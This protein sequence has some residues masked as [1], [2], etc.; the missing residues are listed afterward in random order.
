MQIHL[1][2][3]FLFLT[4]IEAQQNSCL[5]SCC[6]GQSCNLALLPTVYVQYCTLEICIARC[7]AT[8]SQC[9]ENHPYGQISVQCGLNITA[10]QYNCKCDCCNTGSNLCLPSY[11]GNTLTYSCQPGACS[12]A[13]SNQFPY[14]CVSNQNGQ[15]QGTCLGSLTT[16]SVTT[17]VAPWLGNV[18]SC[19][20]CQTGSYCSPTYVGA[21]SAYQCSSTDCTQACRNSYPSSCPSYSNIGRTDG[22]CL[23]STGGNIRCNCRCCGTNGCV[24]DYLISTSGSCGTCDS[25]CRQYTVCPNT[26]QVTYTC[27]VNNNNAK[28]FHT[29]M[30]SIL[31]MIFSTFFIIS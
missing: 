17:T 23:S 27:S 16:T 31:I 26:N 22:I 12:I 19:M 29:S 9:Q 11:V 8:Y 4:T 28:T 15:T 18:C 14:Q 21:T 3:V 6:T 10:P 13:C 25:M 1:F 20:C 5:C 24:N 30:I 2:V 7:R